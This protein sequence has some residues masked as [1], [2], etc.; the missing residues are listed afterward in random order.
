[1]SSFLRRSLPLALAAQ[2]IA[3]VAA[4]ATASAVVLPTVRQLS[5]GYGTLCMVLTNGRIRCSGSSEDGELGNGSIGDGSLRAVTVSGI[6]NAVAM[7]SSRI[8]THS[9]ALLA[10]GTVKC[11]GYNYEGAIGSG[12][13]DIQVSVPETVVG[14]STAT[15]VATGTGFSFWN[16]PK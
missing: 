14:I 4:P 1:M 16:K 11:W 5:A 8:S 9:C 10:D 2:M 7:D 13:G 12:T 3:A 6:T 15:A